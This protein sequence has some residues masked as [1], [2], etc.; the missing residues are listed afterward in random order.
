MVPTPPAELHEC[1]AAFEVAACVVDR[2][3]AAL[4]DVAAAPAVQ[5]SW[6]ERYGVKHEMRR[7][8]EFPPGV[9]PP[10][11]VRIYS[12]GYCY[13]LQWW[14]P[15]AKKTLNVRIDG[16]LI[17]AIARAREIDASLENLGRS[18]HGNP[19]VGHE[20]LLDSYLENL[21]RRADAGQIAV[22]TVE[23][24]EAALGHYRAFV[25]QPAQRKAFPY[26]AGAN[27]DFQLAVAAHLEQL[28][29]AP[30]SHPHAGRRPLRS[31][32]LVLDTVRAMFTWAADPARGNLLPVEF[33]NPF[34]QPDRCHRS[35]AID[36]FGQPDITIAMAVELLGQCDA[37]QLPLFA[38]L[39]LFGLRAAEPVFLF[40]E[41]LDN[42]WLRVACHPG[43]G[44][45]H[46]G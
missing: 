6:S 12:R 8:V 34:Q 33:R 46:Q 22:S 44:V 37:F 10:A 23:R 45:S 13:I 5:I 38:T 15:A 31:P 9:R 43:L 39:A 30:N 25:C 29:V 24:Y 11:R 3:T 18:G 20:V 16:D 14:D 40:R 27:R 2:A 26:P 42:G 21:R 41:D 19:K 4:S 1:A 36:P 35:P 7:V 32:Q 17:D 28:V